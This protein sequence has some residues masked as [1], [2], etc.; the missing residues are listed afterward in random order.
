M[1]RGFL[2]ACIVLFTAAVLLAAG[3]GRSRGRRSDVETVQVSGTVTLNGSPVHGAE[4]NFV[5]EELAASDFTEADGTYT[6][7]AQPGANTVYIR[8]YQGWTPDIEQAVLEGHKQELPPKYSDPAKTEL[9]TT[10]PENDT[11]G[12]DFQLKTR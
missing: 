8:K 9:K 2:T 12:V 6:L 10:V 11:T 3:C 5:A 4:V 1:R 7:Q